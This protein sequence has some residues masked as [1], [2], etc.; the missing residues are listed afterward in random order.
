MSEFS[1]PEREELLTMT[2][3]VERMLADLIHLPYMK[4]CCTSVPHVYMELP[5]ALDGIPRVKP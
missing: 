5:E 1:V 4:A 2:K 3:Q